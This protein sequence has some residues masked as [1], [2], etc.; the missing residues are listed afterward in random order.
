M[1]A[2]WCRMKRSKKNLPLAE[3]KLAASLTNY[4][5][6]SEC[7]AAAETNYLSVSNRLTLRAFRD[8]IA[9]I[10]LR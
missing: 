4:P 8:W 3:P 6:N 9:E 5:N 7:K 10:S 2:I 1:P